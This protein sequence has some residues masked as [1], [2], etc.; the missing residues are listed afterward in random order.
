MKTKY[1]ITTMLTMA[2]LA[3]AIAGCK[4]DQTPI[5]PTPPMSTNAVSN[6]ADSNSVPT[7][8]IKVMQVA[9]TTGLSYGHK[10]IPLGR[11]LYYFNDNDDE[12]FDVVASYLRANTNLVA[13]AV[14]PAG[15]NYSN[16][17]YTGNTS[18]DLH[19]I[20]YN[21]NISNGTFVVFRDK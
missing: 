14:F 17:W 5:P 3:A 11:G 8:D 4:K 2:L 7:P 1:Q 6:T 12:A 9:L 16:G 21:L 19:D 18:I 10:V 15:E 13:V 20:P